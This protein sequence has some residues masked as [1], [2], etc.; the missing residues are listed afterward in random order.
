MNSYGNDVF[1]LA[2][3]CPIGLLVERKRDM[4]YGG[5][6]VGV[7]GVMGLISHVVHD[8]G[9]QRSH[10]YSI[11]STASQDTITRYHYFYSAMQITHICKIFVDAVASMLE[12]K[13]GMGRQT[14]AVEL[15][16]LLIL[17]KNIERFMKALEIKTFGTD[18]LTIQFHQTL[19]FVIAPFCQIAE[20][21]A[22]QPMA[23]SSSRTRARVLYNQCKEEEMG[24]S[25]RS[26]DIKRKCPIELLAMG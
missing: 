14:D 17:G 26:L 15:E 24:S 10:Y 22:D 4:V 6:S 23:K 19:F 11:G 9:C 13:A 2:L 8:G 5:R 12:R 18:Q 7:I 21:E 3:Q 20:E 1:I 25:L 16:F